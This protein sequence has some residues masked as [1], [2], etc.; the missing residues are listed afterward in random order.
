MALA[1]VPTFLEGVL[2]TKNS[3]SDEVKNLLLGPEA[4]QEQF[5]KR[6]HADFK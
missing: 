5:K 4:T 1:K 2:P 3:D 6:D